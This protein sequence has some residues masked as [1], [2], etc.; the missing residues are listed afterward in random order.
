MSRSTKVAVNAQNMKWC[1]EYAFQNRRHMLDLMVDVVEQV[2]KSSPDMEQSVNIHHNFC[3]C[4]SCTYTV[5]A[6]AI[7]CLM[8]ACIIIISQDSCTLKHAMARS[9]AL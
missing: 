2:G 7:S 8:I 4:E 3:Q 5:S 1:Q 6:R 9:V